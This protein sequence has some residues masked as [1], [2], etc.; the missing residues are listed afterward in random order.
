MNSNPGSNPIERV[1][2]ERIAGLVLQTWSKAR[3]FWLVRARPGYVRKNLALRVGQCRRCDRCCSIAFRCYNYNG[4]CSIHGAHYRQCKAFPIDRRDTELI[5]KLGVECGYSFRTGVPQFSPV[6]LHGLPIVVAC[7]GACGLAAAITA[8]FISWWAFLFALPV[9]FVVYF[10]RDPERFP[11]QIGTEVL[12]APADGKVVSVGQGSMPISGKPAYVIDIFLSIF[13]VHVNRSPVAG[14]VLAKKYKAGRFL[15]AIKSS[16]A[17]ENESNTLAIGS[18]YGPRIEVTQV[19]GAIARRIVCTAD[20]GER[21]EA[22]ER[23]GMI[24]FGSRTRLF[25]PLDV[26]F[27]ATVQIGQKVKGGSTV[28]GRFL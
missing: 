2:Q 10:F 17:E 1:R 26:P 12:L 24:R 3:R 18:D 14:Q 8:A 28:L 5:R 19:S 20:E 16:A 15:N 13:N 7:L 4:G 23:F 6:S 22:G 9:A 27:E 11:D 25:I 21:L